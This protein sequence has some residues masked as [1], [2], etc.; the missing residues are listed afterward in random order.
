MKTIKKIIVTILICIMTAVP[1][2]SFSSCGSIIYID[3]IVFNGVKYVRNEHT[4]MYFSDLHWFNEEGDTFVGGTLVGETRDPTS[5]LPTAT[6]PIYIDDLD[7]EKNVIHLDPMWLDGTFYV[8]EGVDLSNVFDLE[9]TYVECG[10]NTSEGRLES[11]F[12]LN[13]YISQTPVPISKLPEVLRVAQYFSA[14]LVLCPS[15]HTYIDVYLGE[16]RIFLQAENDPGYYEV[17]DETF[18]QLMMDI[19]FTEKE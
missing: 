19:C 9:L 6:A 10:Y 8:K 3:S 12:K 16:G 11:G 5:I 1:L 2:F 14:H 18:K 17:T 4:E 7:V 15:L 13:D